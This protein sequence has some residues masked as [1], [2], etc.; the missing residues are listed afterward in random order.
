MTTLIKSGTFS[1]G[2]RSCQGCEAEAFRGISMY[3][4]G[5]EYAFRVDSQHALKMIRNADSEEEIDKEEEFYMLEEEEF[6]K[7]RRANKTDH[8]L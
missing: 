3:P 6:Y 5:N 8:L 7:L 1:P 2:E 4:A